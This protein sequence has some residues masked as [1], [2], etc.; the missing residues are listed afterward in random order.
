MFLVTG[1]MIANVRIFTNGE[2]IGAWLD[3][4]CVFVA[5]AWWPWRRRND[6]REERP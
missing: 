1:L 4:V 6:R 5:G 3:L 2:M